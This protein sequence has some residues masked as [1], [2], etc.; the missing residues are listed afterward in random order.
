MQRTKLGRDRALHFSKGIQELAYLCVGREGESGPQANLFNQ[1]RENM[2][3]TG[4][5]GREISRGV[6]PNPNSSFFERKW[7]LTDSAIVGLVKPLALTFVSVLLLGL[8]SAF[9]LSLVHVVLLIS[10]LAD[11]SERRV[12]RHLVG[13]NFLNFLL[14]LRLLLLRLLPDD[15]L[16]WLLL[17]AR[18]IVPLLAHGHVVCGG[19]FIVRLN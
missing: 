11:I 10:A 6:G 16:L 13:G 8:R 19:D 2:G 5:N 1:G 9:A 17:G 18:V 15:E 4:L 3:G 14:I 7:R 12:Q